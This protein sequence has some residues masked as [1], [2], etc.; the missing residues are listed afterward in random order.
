MLSTTLKSVRKAE[1]EAEQSIAEAKERAA[2][3]IEEAKA[4][5]RKIDHDAKLTASREASEKIAAAEEKAAAAKEAYARELENSLAD[6]KAKA[7][8]QTD[9]VVEQ[10]VAMLTA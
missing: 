5:A 1:K 9:S 10:V 4:S 6:E 8:A 7:Q 3:I 2:Q